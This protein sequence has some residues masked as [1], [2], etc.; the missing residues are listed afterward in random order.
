MV[1]MHAQ[2]GRAKLAEKLGRWK[3][4][5]IHRTM[6]FMDLARGSGSKVHTPALQNSLDASQALLAPCSHP[7]VSALHGTTDVHPPALTPP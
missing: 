1:V 2:E 4:E 3:L 6:D 5:D 7:L